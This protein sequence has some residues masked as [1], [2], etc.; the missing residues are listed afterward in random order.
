M[1][2][3]SSFPRYEEFDPKVPVWCITPQLDGCTHRF[4]DTSPISPSGRYVGL[5]R[6]IGENNTPAPGEK[7]EIIVVDLENGDQRVVAETF[8]GDT[9]LGAQVQWGLSD[10][11]FYYGDLDIKTWKPFT[12]RLNIFTNER[13][14][15][16]GPLYMLSPD[17]AK[18]LSPCLIRTAMTQNGYGV[19]VPTSNIPINIHADPDDGIYVT[20]IE[21]GECRLL[22][23]FLDIFEA[24]KPQ[25]SDDLHKDGAFYGFHVKWNPQGTRIMFSIRYRT[26]KGD[27]QTKMPTHLVTMNADGSD[28]KMALHSSLRQKGGHHP[29]WCPD[30]EYITQNLNFDGTGLKFARFRFD[31]QDLKVLA[32]GIPGSGHPSVHKSGKYLSTDCYISDKMAYGDGTTPIRFI[33]LENGT[34]Q[35]IIRIRTLPDY[36]GPQSCRRVDPH[37]AWDQSGRYIT[38][39]GYA[40][41]KRQVFIADL[42]SL[43][44]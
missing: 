3:H 37:P 33:D 34:E 17:G 24:L 27:D 7:A 11:E 13:K 4:F 18:M 31:G 25:F 10:N 2:I 12:V 9:Q 6:F 38:F 19:R 36:R 28:I 15:L 1:N 23:S 41:G 26:N 30:G 22:V 29:N 44:K 8:G 5:T 16:R 43:I 21:S 20:E 40:N 39:N 14:V 42:K 32:E 35:H